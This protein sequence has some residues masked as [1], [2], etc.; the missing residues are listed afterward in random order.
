MRR[1]RFSRTASGSSPVLSPRL[2]LVYGPRLTPPLRLV[3]K[4]L[5]CGEQASP[6]RSSRR[7]TSYGLAQP[8]EEFGH[9]VRQRGVPRSR[10]AR[11]RMHE[12]Q[13]FRVQRLAPKV[14]CTARPLRAF[15]TV[16]GVADERV[17]DGRKVH[18]YLVRA[19]G[20]ETAS[21]QCRLRKRLDD[22]VMGNRRLAARNDRHA[23]ALHG[24]PS[25]RRLH[26]TL[27]CDTSMHQ[28][29]IL[30]RHRT[31]L[32]LAHEVSVSGERLRD[33][34]QSARVLVEAMHDPGARHL[35]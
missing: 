3:M 16:Y 34:Q 24:V 22:A 13:L 2:K 8:D 32:E 11:R 17:P 18:P 33:H 29:E 27:A 21:Q 15:R 28:R 5:T 35:A 10:A 6:E 7:G 25:D 4:A 9:I 1:A 19:T 31:G 20:L 14:D 26:H 30:A 23:R 12:R